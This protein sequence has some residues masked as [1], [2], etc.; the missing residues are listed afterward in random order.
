[1]NYSG[2][3]FKNKIVAVSRQELGGTEETHGLSTFWSISQNTFSF[4][5]IECRQSTLN[6]LFFSLPKRESI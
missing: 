3:E 6:M 5:N 2:K 4:T 1:M